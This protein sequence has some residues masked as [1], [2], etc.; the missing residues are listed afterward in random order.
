VAT[1]A[2]GMA[3]GVWQRKVNDIKT[4]TMLEKRPFLSVVLPVYNTAPFLEEAVN[5][6]LHQTMAD[7][8][9]I[10]VNDGSTDNSEEIIRKLLPRD[11]RLRYH[12]LEKNSGLSVARNEGFRFVRGEYVYFMDSDDV[13]YAT[14]FDLAR[15]RCERDR[16]QV[17]VCNADIFCEEGS[18]LPPYHYH[19][20]GKYSETEVYDG[21][22]LLYKMLETRTF[23]SVSWVHFISVSWIKELQ[24]EF[25]PGIIH[26]DQL[27]TC[28]LMMQTQRMGCLNKSLIAHRMRAES[29]TTKRYSWRNVSCYLVV[30]NELFAFAHKRGK[31]T[32]ALVKFYARY[33]L[34][35]V[36][37]TAKV[38]T[39]SEKFKT[40]M[41]FLRT[42]YWR[43][44]TPRTIGAFLLKH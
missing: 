25:Y 14:A 9:V 7:F 27:Y 30:V 3:Q 11:G 17:L 12:K 33:T 4:R 20:L 22:N 5:S 19:H 43:Y 13:L 1:L 40:V 28:L 37:Q 35:P 18:S 44:L 6:I 29:I 24:I 21:F 34:N 42:G 39:P 38:L 31:D 26:E 8:E 23:C 41:A 16:L 36:L 10:I 32:L 2:G 15:E